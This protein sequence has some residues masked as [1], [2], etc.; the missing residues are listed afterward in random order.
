M[1][2]TMEMLGLAIPGK[3]VD[4]VGMCTQSAG[5]HPRHF[6][7]R[8]ERAVSNPLTSLEEMLSRTKGS[9]PHVHSC[10]IV[11]AVLGVPWK[12]KPGKT[13]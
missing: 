8:M 10:N 5:E 11:V 12:L 7:P 9:G 3:R 6:E 13:F 4:R 2:V 1:N